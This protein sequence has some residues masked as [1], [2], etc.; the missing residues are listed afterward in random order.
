MQTIHLPG[1]AGAVSNDSGSLVI[2]DAP[3]IIYFREGSAGLYGFRRESFDPTTQKFIVGIG[4]PIILE[5]FFCV[6]THTR[7]EI[8]ENVRCTSRGK[9]LEPYEE[10]HDLM[11][12]GSGSSLSL[13]ISFC[14]YQFFAS[15]PSA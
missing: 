5:L 2:N 9:F 6:E 1:R 13:N 12:G 11:S 4:Y 7:H 3:K 14:Q 8:K 10:S 15:L